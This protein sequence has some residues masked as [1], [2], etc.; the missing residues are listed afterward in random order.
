MKTPMRELKDKMLIEVAKLTVESLID[1]FIRGY[2][3]ALINIANDIESQ[4][5]EKEKQQI[6][7]FLEW[8]DGDETNDLYFETSKE[9][10]DRYYAETFKK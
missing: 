10:V 5:L 8:I 3:Y 4:M 2:R 1:E 9:W 6:I 7:D